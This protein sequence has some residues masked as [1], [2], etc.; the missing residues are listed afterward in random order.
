MIDKKT[1]SELASQAKAQGID[2]W[3]VSAVINDGPSVLLLERPPADFMGGIYELPSGKVEKGEPLDEALIREVAEETGLRVN[4]IC[5][6]IGFFDY[7]SK[8]GKKTRQFNFRV[9]V[10][11]PIKVVLTEHISYAWVKKEELPKYKITEA[12]AGTLDKFW[13]K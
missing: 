5:R 13:A 6:Y 8:S 4:E 9:G 11:L 1:Y 2:R 3:V 7:T 12:V 10:I